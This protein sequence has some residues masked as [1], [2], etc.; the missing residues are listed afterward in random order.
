MA[1]THPK[2]YSTLAHASLLHPCRRV[3]QVGLRDA[4][5]QRRASDDLLLLAPRYDGQAPLL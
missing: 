3:G 5:L 2:P 1:S 4:D